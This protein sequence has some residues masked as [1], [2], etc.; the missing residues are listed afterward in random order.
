MCICQAPAV[1][2][3][4]ASSGPT[5]DPPGGSVGPGPVLAPSLEGRYGEAV[6]WGENSE[7][8][9]ETVG[10]WGEIVGRWGVTVGR[11]RGHQA[12]GGRGG[13]SGW[14]QWKPPSLPVLV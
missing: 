5:E 12:D 13:D 14:C 9:G 8:V 7:K 11:W 2:E 1:G 10:R 6:G 4:L 3:L